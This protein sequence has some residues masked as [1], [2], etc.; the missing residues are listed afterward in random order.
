MPELPFRGSGGSAIFVCQSPTP[1]GRAAI[2]DVGTGRLVNEGVNP[3]RP[4][5]PLKLYI[6]RMSAIRHSAIEPQ[7]GSMSALGH[8]RTFCEVESMSALP[9]KKWTCAV[10]LVMSAK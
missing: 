5:V 10:Q 4:Q 2:D 9:P 3:Q 6:E 1:G 8:K 7:V